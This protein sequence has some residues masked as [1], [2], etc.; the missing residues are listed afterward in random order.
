M[1]EMNRQYEVL[2]TVSGDRGTLPCLKSFTNIKGIIFL[3]DLSGW[4]YTFDPFGK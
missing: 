2:E 1:I 4:K 3:M